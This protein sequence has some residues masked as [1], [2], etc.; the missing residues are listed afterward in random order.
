MG[1]SKIR[2]QLLVLG[3]LLL[4]SLT[5]GQY[6]SILTPYADSSTY[7]FVLRTEEQLD[8]RYVALDNMTIKA[9]GDTCKVYYMHYGEGLVSSSMIPFSVFNHFAAFEKKVINSACEKPECT[10]S[11]LIEAGDQQLRVHIDIL[12]VELL[13]SFM[14]E[15][16]R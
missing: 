9:D 15:L 14:L 2:Q 3:S 12:Y 10:Y 6:E 8:D 5:F 13:S 11:I 4:S 16:E 7:K 1:M